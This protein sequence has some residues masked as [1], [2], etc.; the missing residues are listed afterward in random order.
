[1]KLI[2]DSATDVVIGASMCG[3]DAPEIIQV[4]SPH[5]LRK[6]I[7]LPIMNKLLIGVLFTF[8]QGVAI[9]LKCGATKA[10]FD[11][12]VRALKMS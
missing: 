2:V 1:M 12:T 8:P 9:A 5:Y 10:Q 6:L 3:P 4:C 11:S 7:I